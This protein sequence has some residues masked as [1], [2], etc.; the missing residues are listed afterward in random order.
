MAHDF[1][2]TW[3]SDDVKTIAQSISSISQR[4]RAIVYSHSVVTSL[5]DLNIFMIYIL[6]IVLERDFYTSGNNRLLFRFKSGMGSTYLERTVSGKSAPFK[7]LPVF[8]Y[9]DRAL[10][11]EEYKSSNNDRQTNMTKMC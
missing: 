9:V 10:H 3:Q 8:K 2:T 6:A 7:A 11:T 4:V 1:T 5:V